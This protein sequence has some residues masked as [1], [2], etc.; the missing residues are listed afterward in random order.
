MLCA[1]SHR[2]GQDL[3]LSIYCS[4]RKRCMGGATGDPG[5]PERRRQDWRDTVQAVPCSSPAHG[6]LWEAWQRKALLF[7]FLRAKAIWRPVAGTCLEA[8]YTIVETSH[9]LNLKECS[10]LAGSLQTQEKLIKWKGRRLCFPSQTQLLQHLTLQ[11][12]KLIT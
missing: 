11:I 8:F 1:L 7:C 3:Q 4:K 9:K 5:L 6:E 12:C 10:I 2:S